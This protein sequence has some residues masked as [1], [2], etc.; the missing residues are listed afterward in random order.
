MPSTNQAPCDMENK[1][2]IIPVVLSPMSHV[3]RAVGQR[4][5][6]GR[7]RCKEQL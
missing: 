5:D 1:L 2:E 3:R 7:W 6:A 4:C